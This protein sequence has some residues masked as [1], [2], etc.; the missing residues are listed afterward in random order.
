MNY[1]NKGEKF[2]GLAVL[3]IVSLFTNHSFANAGEDSATILV[4]D[5]STK[6]GSVLKSVIV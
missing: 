6:T 1:Y 3:L 5:N 2:C 4:T